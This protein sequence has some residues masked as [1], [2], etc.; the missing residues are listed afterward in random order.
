M[1]LRKE[2]RRILS[3]VAASGCIVLAGAT[4][5]LTQGLPGL[6]IFSGVDRANELGFRLQNDGILNRRDRYYLRIPAEKLDLA[7]DLFIVT[8]PEE[9]DADFDCEESVYSDSGEIVEF[10][11]DLEESGA[12]EP[13]DVFLDCT[14]SIELRISGD[15]IPVDQVLWDPENQFVEIYPTQPVPARSRVEL[16]FSNVDN[17]SRTGTH[18]F[19]ALVRSPGDVVGPQYVGTW[20][21]SFGRF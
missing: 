4:S 15:T 21:L 6:T 16:V 8:Y 1:V 11:D 3:A 20:I 5:G 17:P 14:D 13:S 18:Y 7:S 10:T 12:Y 19:N 2:F 9:Y